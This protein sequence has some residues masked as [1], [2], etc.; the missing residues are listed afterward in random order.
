[1]KKA[2]IDSINL[3]SEG[4][5]EMLVAKNLI[6][7][8]V[9]TLTVFTPN[10][11]REEFGSKLTRNIK[12]GKIAHAENGVAIPL[13]RFINA[14]Q[15]QIME[16][17]GM[18]GYKERSKLLN[19]V[20]DDLRLLLQ[21]QKIQR[22]DICIDFDSIPQKVIKKLC[23]V[24]IPFAFRNT[25]YFKTPNEKKKNQVMD[26]KLYDKK[27]ADRLDFSCYRLEFVFH[28]R[29][30]KNIKLKDVDLMFE[31]IEKSI[32]KFTNLSV[33]ISSFTRA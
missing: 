14:P 17:A 18:N 3:A 7:E 6:I 27:K 23:E 29:Y 15:I 21:N 8:D 28:S 16:F 11:W 32:L 22:I 33:K 1:M 13:K 31:K 10:R 19:D 9:K 24:R 20:F 5:E 4:F 25:T 2:Y 26:I 12:E 30:L